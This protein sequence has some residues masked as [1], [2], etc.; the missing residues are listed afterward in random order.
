MKLLD[1]NVSA[2]MIIVFIWNVNVVKSINR[3][4]LQ[5]FCNFE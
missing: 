1:S 3:L 4:L 2:I 5:S